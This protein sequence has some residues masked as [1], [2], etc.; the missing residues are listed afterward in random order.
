MPVRAEHVCD[1]VLQAGLLELAGRQVDADLQRD[2]E[3]V[4]PRLR[5]PAGLL[6]HGLPDGQDGAVVLGQLDE[7]RRGQDAVLGVVPTDQG[8]GPDD[9]LVGER[10]QRLV[11][12]LD[13]AALDGVVERGVEVEPAGRT[14]AHPVH[15]EERDLATPAALLGPVHGHV[16]IVQE[17]V[18]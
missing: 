5:L 8:L 2:A 15:V 3:R 16:G 6:E 1:L 13:L 9:A 17:I 10:D 18:A 14:A 7:L 11:V 12:D 4:V